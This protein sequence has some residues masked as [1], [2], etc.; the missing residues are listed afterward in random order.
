MFLKF[1]FRRQRQRMCR[2]E[3]RSV[4]GPG[5]DRGVYRG[6]VGVRSEGCSGGSGGGLGCGC[7]TYLK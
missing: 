5:R 2:S 7:S 3:R 4:A 6:G 1:Y